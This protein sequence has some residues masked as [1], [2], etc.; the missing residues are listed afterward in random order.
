MQTPLTATLEQVLVMV[1]HVKVMMHESQSPAPTII[2]PHW[3][4]IHYRYP[5][6]LLRGLSWRPAASSNVR[7]VPAEIGITREASARGVRLS[8]R[9]RCDRA[10]GHCFIIVLFSRFFHWQIIGGFYQSRSPPGPTA[11]TSVRRNNSRDRRSPLL[12]ISAAPSACLCGTYCP[13]VNARN[14]VGTNGEANIG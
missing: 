11:R 2:S 14:R 5:L 9:R 7:S 12:S 4:I 10:L 1:V 3:L 13:R 8:G 6:S